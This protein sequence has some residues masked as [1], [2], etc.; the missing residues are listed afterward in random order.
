M[1]ETVPLGTRIDTLRKA[2]SSL[3]QEGVEILTAEVSEHRDPQIHVLHTPGL[4]LMA[5][6]RTR[7]VFDGHRHLS[8]PYQGCELLWID[9]TVA[10]ADQV[11]TTNQERIAA[12]G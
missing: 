2:V 4:H 3:R 9:P 5:G 7:C 1:S 11:V 12:H 6:I 10:V 8:A